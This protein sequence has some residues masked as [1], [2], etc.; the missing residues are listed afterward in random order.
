M[1]TILDGFSCILDNLRLELVFFLVLT[2]MVLRSSALSFLV[3]PSFCF[4]NRNDK[5]ASLLALPRFSFA[6]LTMEICP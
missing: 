6:K 3:H 4:H 2:V 5:D 1:W